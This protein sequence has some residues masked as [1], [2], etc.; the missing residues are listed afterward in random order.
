MEA[1]NHLWRLIRTTDRIKVEKNKQLFQILD[2]ILPLMNTVTLRKMLKSLSL[3][4]IQRFFYKFIFIQAFFPYV[5]VLYIN[6]CLVL[7]T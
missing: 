1:E 4:K 6:I 5:Y 7:A 3:P 2:L